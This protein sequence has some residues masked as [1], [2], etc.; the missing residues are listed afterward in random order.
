MRREMTS[1]RKAGRR[2]AAATL[3][4]L[5]C[6]GYAHGDVQPGD[7]I[8]PENADR[9]EGLVSP[10]VHWMVRR[11]MRVTVAETQPIPMPPAYL[12]ATQRYSGGVRLS[13]D[14]RA[15]ENWTA[16]LPFP[17]LDRNDPDIARKVMYNFDSRW[18]ESD[19]VNL[20]N[21]DADS[22]PIA[23]GPRGMPVEKHFVIE[24]FRRMYFTARLM[25]EPKP[26]FTPNNDEV[27]YKESLH[28]LIEPFDLKGVGFTYYRYLDPERQDDSWLYLPQLRR[29]RRL[30]S[31]QRSDALFGQDTDQDSYGGYA[32]NI[33]WMDWKFI[34]QKTLLTPVHGV[35]FPVNWGKGSS[36]FTFDDVWEPRRVYVI[37]ATSKLNQYAYG[38]RIIFV[39][40]EAFFIPYTDIYD[41]AGELWKV[42]LNNYHFAQE[43]WTDAGAEG[44]Y[45]SPMPFLP[46]IVMVDIQRDHVTRAALPSRSFE[47]EIGWR[48][49]KGRDEGNTEEFF[50]VAE[51]IQAGR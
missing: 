43:P 29:V 35:H 24:H 50:S 16:G 22:G 10:G 26:A 28:P 17:Q 45:P 4:A 12:E 40:E 7:V 19:D 30:S 27:R 47:R 15:I 9:I 20:R 14:K 39:D 42:W 38:K 49:N 11:G 46:G 31:A 1:R 6:A 5:S 23:T 8:T 33:S 25:L 21:L 2:L 51:L 37:E 18:W 41:R 36:D 48:F 13:A 3:L 44:K 34:G 32:G